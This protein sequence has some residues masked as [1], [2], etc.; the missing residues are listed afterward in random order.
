[1][2]DATTPAL[3]LEGWLLRQTPPAGAVWLTQVRQ[4]LV[5]A[6]PAQALQ[7]AISGVPRRLGRQPLSL[8]AGD[9]AAAHAACPGW[10]PGHWSVDQA[11]RVLLLLSGSAD[12]EP[13]AERLGRLSASADLGELVAFYRGLPLYPDPPSYLTW[14]I[15]GLRTSMRTVFEAVAHENPYPAAQ[16][17]QAAWNQMV[18][19]ALFIEST[20][21]PI[22]G[23]DR[24]SNPALARMLCNYAHERWAAG[25][26]VTY[27]L[28]RCVGPHAD[29]AAVQ[30]LGR[31]LASGSDLERQAAALALSQSTDPNA[32]ALLGSV[33]DLA[34]MI[35][36]G[37]LDWQALHAQGTAA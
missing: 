23:L 17:P 14:T 10:Q 29:A 22:D 18:L 35:A 21:H 11:A 37:G 34:A 32:A 12:V 33:P 26:P 28:W 20:L 27:E 3:L 19:K 13:L 5:R 8:S 9:L 24:R 36:A 1:M 6:A 16:F 15:E 25:R 31:V 7:R 4:E 2:P 30:D